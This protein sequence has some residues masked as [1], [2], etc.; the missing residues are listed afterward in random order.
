LALQTGT[1]PALEE[2]KP[3]FLGK[4]QVKN[5]HVV[6]GGLSFVGS[7]F[8]VEGSIDR[9]AFFLQPFAEGA[10]QGLMIFDKQDPHERSPSVV[11]DRPP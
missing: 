7:L 3:I 10:D 11:L 9:E 8:T 1:P 6:I 2:R 5:D 4:H